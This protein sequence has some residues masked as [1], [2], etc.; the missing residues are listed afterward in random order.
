MIVLTMGVSG[1]GKTTLASALAERLDWYF[2]E[3]DD[4]HPPSNIAKM[5]AGHPLTDSDRG[6]WL[7][8]LSERL[9]ELSGPSWHRGRVLCPQGRLSASAAAGPS[10]VAA[11]LLKGCPQDLGQRLV[12]RQGHYMPPALLRSQ[13]ETL[14]EPLNTEN[15]LVPDGNGSFGAQL[16]LALA[17]I[18]GTLQ[19]ARP[20]PQRG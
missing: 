10:R 20:P 5:S 4:F 6:P 13:F 11:Y 18:E 17:A 2:V 9:C 12:E 7:H 3:A 19:S 15:A 8:A 1:V 16:A 14:E